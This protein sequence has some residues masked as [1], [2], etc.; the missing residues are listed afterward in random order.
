MLKSND[1]TSDRCWNLCHLNECSNTNQSMA[2]KHDKDIC[3]Y[4]EKC[5]H[6]DPDYEDCIE[7]CIDINNLMR[8]KPFTYKNFLKYHRQCL[9][10]DHCKGR[11]SLAIFSEECGCNYNHNAGT[12]FDDSCCDYDKHIKSC[13]YQECYEC[14]ECKCNYDEHSNSCHGEKCRQSDHKD[15]CK[16]Y[17]CRACVGSDYT[18]SEDS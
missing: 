1:I 9:G 6:Y 15:G 17:K 8:I 13:K 5:Y 12:C 3:Q 11:N 18:S 14:A 4:G 10:E 7:F 2:C 16:Y